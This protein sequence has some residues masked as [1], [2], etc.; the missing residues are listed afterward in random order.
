MSA[1]AAFL[2]YCSKQLKSASASREPKQKRK[3]PEQLV[4]MQIKKWA[5]ENGLSLNTVESKIMFSAGGGSI[6]S[7]TDVG[8]SDLVGCDKNGFAVYIEAKAPGS[9]SNVRP[10]QCLFLIEKIRKN[11]FA[12]VADSAAYCDTHYKIWLSLGIEERKNYLRELLPNK[13]KKIL[14]S[15]SF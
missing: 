5:K 10:A 11:C 1:K 6:R 3:K 7:Q 9:R 8:I 14:S 15:E 13:A 12:I 4:V 2:K